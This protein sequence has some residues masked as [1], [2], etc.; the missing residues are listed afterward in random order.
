[1]LRQLRDK[2]IYLKELLSMYSWFSTS[3]LNFACLIS[4]CFKYLGKNYGYLCE[5]VHLYCYSNCN[6]HKLISN[7]SLHN[8]HLTLIIKNSIPRRIKKLNKRDPPTPAQ[9]PNAHILKRY[10]YL[11]MVELLLGELQMLKQIVPF[12]DPTNCPLA[13]VLS[14]L[15]QS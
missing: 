8:L 10:F 6:L 14:C 2:Y 7:N 15:P 1:M 11:V 5:N 12:T 4:R 3:L 13:S 9:L